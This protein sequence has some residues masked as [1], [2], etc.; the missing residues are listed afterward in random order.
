M[1]LLLAPGC[2]R[3]VFRTVGSPFLFEIFSLNAK[4]CLASI[5]VYLL[6]CLYTVRKQADCG[7]PK[8]TR[9]YFV[10]QLALNFLK[11]PKCC[12]DIL[13]CCCF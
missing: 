13:S 10:P 7:I 5:T 2:G 6:C 1:L 4:C 9:L 3:P 12:M 8:L 11:Q